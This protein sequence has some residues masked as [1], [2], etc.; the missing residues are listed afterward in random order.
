MQEP[1]RLSKAREEYNSKKDYLDKKIL[2]TKDSLSIFNHLIKT[3]KLEIYGI[4]PVYD[5]FSVIN[6]YFLD[7][8]RRTDKFL[9]YCPGSSYGVFLEVDSEGYLGESWDD[10]GGLSGF[11]SFKPKT[12]IIH[13]KSLDEKINQT[14]NKLDWEIKIS[15]EN[16]EWDNKLIIESLRNELRYL[17]DKFDFL[18]DG[19]NRNYIF[20]MLLEVNISQDELINNLKKFHSYVIG[21]AKRHIKY[22][23]ENLS[24]LTE[25]RNSLEKTLIDIND[26]DSFK[27]KIIS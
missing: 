20:N 27:G 8:F 16:P 7:N 14:R 15:K 4:K 3:Y 12:Q 21:H 13:R 24:K 11:N 26:L 23:E 22:L 1:N 6:V 9:S 10:G 2:Q 25:K 17:K 18:F 19:S 5:S